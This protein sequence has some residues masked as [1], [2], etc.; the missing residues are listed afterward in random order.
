MSYNKVFVDL[1]L[2][3]LGMLRCRREFGRMEARVRDH[4]GYVVIEVR[5]VP[6]EPANVFLHGGW[7]K[8]VFP[9]RPTSASGSRRAMILTFQY[10]GIGWYRCHLAKNLFQYGQ[11][12]TARSRAKDAAKK[13]EEET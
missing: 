7:V 10:C 12:A 11:T 9:V 2:N 3:N 1:T 8:Q 5:S 4:D 6:G 13:T